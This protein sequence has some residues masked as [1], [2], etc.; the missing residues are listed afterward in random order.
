M[1]RVRPGWAIAS[2]GVIGILVGFALIGLATAGYAGPNATLFLIGLGIST[3]LLGLLLWIV[4]KASLTNDSQSASSH[5]NV[6]PRAGLGPATN[7][8]P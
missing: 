8:S 3:I 4:G 7:G 2:Q 1:R 5:E 6:A